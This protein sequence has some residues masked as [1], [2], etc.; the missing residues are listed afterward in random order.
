MKN[1]FVILG[2][3]G[4]IGRQLLIHAARE[5]KMGIKAL[6]Y[7]EIPPDVP[8]SAHIKIY[9]GSAFDRALLRKILREGDTVIDLIGIT[10]AS[11]DADAQFQLNTFSHRFVLE[12]CVRKKV[13]KVVFLSTI[14]IYRPSS[15]A[16]SEEDAPHPRDIYSL[17]KVLGE[18]IYEYFHRLYGIPVVIL[19]LGSVYGPGQ[20]K[21]IVYTLAQ[22]ARKSGTITIPVKPLY[23]DFI[24]IAD[25]L[26][27]I[28]KAAI[29]ATKGFERFNISNSQRVSLSAVAAHVVRR[30]SPRA[31]VIKK[32]NPPLL[33]STFADTSK[34]K[35]RLHF[36]PRMPF[37]RGLSETLSSYGLLPIDR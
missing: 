20:Q 2:A 25:V 32:R 17:T 15:K 18:A 22:S 1:S 8:R 28:M 11:D 24:F 7:R 30:V 13:K 36:V 10:T 35:S 19:R 27:A 37:T 4:Y 3:D 29:F 23:R 14:N 6:V 9:K 34:A 5:H 33:F 26:D 12:E 16:A 21:G 31:S